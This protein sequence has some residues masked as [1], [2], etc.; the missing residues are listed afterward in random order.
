MAQDGPSLLGAIIL[1]AIQ[2]LTEFL[3]VSSSGHL[4]LAQAFIDVGSEDVFFDL[5]L[6]LGTL[7]P[8]FVFFRHDILMVVRDL[9]TGHVPYWSRPGVR[10][11]AM[12]IAATLPTAI[13]GLAFKE[14][15]DAM[16]D[17]QL[18]NA[19]C[20]ALTALMLMATRRMQTGTQKLGELPLSTAVLTG[21]AQGISIAPAISRSGATIATAMFL[22]MEKEAAFRF[23]FLMSFPAILGAFAL[24]ARKVDHV[25]SVL[26]PYVAGAVTS[27]IL[28][29]ASLVAL[30]W[31]V[32]KGR[33]ADFSWYVWL[34]AAASLAVWWFGAPTA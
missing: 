29:Y 25:P 24:E 2:G 31:L 19:V 12:V 6:H 22:G 14:Q 5:V 10:L 1:G 13:I 4:V 8:A 27:M 16:F 3:P 18:L 20:F 34:M 30:E 11:S 26:L 32:R 21:I 33:F 17:D 28:G 7:V 15:F 9:F 23:S